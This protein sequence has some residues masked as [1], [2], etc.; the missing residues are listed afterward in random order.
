[1]LFFHQKQ[2]SQTVKTAR[3]LKEQTR[4]CCKHT[5]VLFFKKYSL[6]KKRS[7]SPLI[8][9]HNTLRSSSFAVRL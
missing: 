3:Q 6:E 9:P 8:P 4:G 7:L 5:H 1:V 2:I